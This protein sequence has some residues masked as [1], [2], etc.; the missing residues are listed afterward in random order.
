M[1]MYER[2]LQILLDDARYRRVEAAARERQTSVAA[3]IRDAI[4][5]ALPVDLERKREAARRILEADP[6]PV[7]ETVEELKREL[8]EIRSGGL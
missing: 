1:C 5:K 7:P 8:D 6:I 4:D 2:R 3:V